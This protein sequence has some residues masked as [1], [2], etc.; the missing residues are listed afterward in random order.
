MISSIGVGADRGLAALGVG[1][2]REHSVSWL[3]HFCYSATAKDRPVK[4]EKIT[5]TKCVAVLV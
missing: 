1:G 3:G 5:S 2:V 4:L